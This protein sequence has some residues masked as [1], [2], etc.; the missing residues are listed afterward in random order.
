MRGAG[1]RA[2]ACRLRRFGDG[3]LWLHADAPPP[4]EQGGGSADGQCRWLGFDAPKPHERGDGGALAVC[5]GR[6]MDGNGKGGALAYGNVGVGLATAGVGRDAKRGF[7]GGNFGGF[8]ASS[9]WSPAAF[10]RVS[11]GFLR[12]FPG[13][14]PH[15]VPWGYSRRL[16]T[17]FQG[18][19]GRPLINCR[20]RAGGWRVH[21]RFPTV[22]PA[23][24][25]WI[26]SD[27]FPAVFPME[28]PGDI[29]GGCGL[30]FSAS[31]GDC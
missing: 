27:S 6:R 25:G 20:W 26:H 19:S 9:R 30:F 24:L 10:Q 5:D 8:P 22:F 18:L 14:V 23:G 15:G 31:P 11:G 2:G 3:A 16:R 28:F 1:P 13:S 7:P 4:Y 17:V 21:M 29:P 12:Q